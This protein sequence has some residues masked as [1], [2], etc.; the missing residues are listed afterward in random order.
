MKILVIRFSSIGDIVL[1]SPV[2]RWLKNKYPESEIHFLCKKQFIN[3]VEQNPNV[4]KVWPLQDFNSTAKALKNEKFE[5][6]VDL[7]KNLRSYRFRWAIKAPRRASFKK[8]S[9]AKY[10]SV[11]FKKAN[12]LPNKHIVDRYAEGLK[13]VEV[14]NDGL[15]LSFFGE[16]E[17]ALFKE[18]PAKYNVLVAGAAHNTKKL[19]ESLI[20]KIRKH[21]E[22]PLVVLGTAADNKA[23]FSE[24]DVI[25]LCGSTSL[26]ESAYIIKH[27]QSVY[28]SD[29][30]L[31]HIAA[32]F[33]K[34][35]HIFWG[36]TVPEFGMYPYK[37][38]F[39]NHEVKNL[40]CRPC[41]KIG[42]AECPKGHFKCM[43]DQV[44]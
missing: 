20:Q 7:H 32:A 42:F 31:M 43:E 38:S 22:I 28:T 40:S 10:F 19:P 27:A 24:I 18:L 1:C 8:L 30:G 35:I 11:R 36:S 37:T 34:Q 4:D 33:E 6:V 12:F 25:N 29:T 44:L 15:G 41:S 23:I 5:L 9:V 14:E 2:L 13:Y 17:P 39:V 21:S 3:L 16:V 26:N